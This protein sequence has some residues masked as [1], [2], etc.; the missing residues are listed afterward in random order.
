VLKFRG[1]LNLG[2]L[3]N[4]PPIDVTRLVSVKDRGPFKTE[5]ANMFSM[6]FSLLSRREREEREKREKR[7]RRERRERR[8]TLDVSHASA[9]LNEDA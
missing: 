5:A 6:V 3:L 9:L 2:A 4:I 8:E 7:E 1:W